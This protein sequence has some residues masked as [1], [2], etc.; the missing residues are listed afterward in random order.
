[1]NKKEIE[2]MLSPLDIISLISKYRKEKG[3]TLKE[4][5]ELTNTSKSTLSRIESRETEKIDYSLVIKLKQALDISDEDILMSM[6]YM[7][8]EKTKQ[9]M[10]IVEI[11]SEVA[12]CNVCGRSTFDN[13]I[14]LE[15]GNIKELKLGHRNQCQCI[16]LCKTC[17][18]NLRDLLNR[19]LLK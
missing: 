1:M 11:D 8:E 10:E 15:V 13:N 2:F 4:L 19:D 16:S 14:K 9:N 7:E 17:R 18:E 6:N 12:R 5:A 3:I